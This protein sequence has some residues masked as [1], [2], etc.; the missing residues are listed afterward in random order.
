MDLHPSPLT[1][2]IYACRG[3]DLSGP[4]VNTTTKHSSVFVGRYV[5]DKTLQRPCPHNLFKFLYT[6]HI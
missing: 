3:A 6:L 2:V 4:D 5:E 1:A